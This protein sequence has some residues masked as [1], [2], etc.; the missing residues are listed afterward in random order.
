MAWGKNET[1]TEATT[2]TTT[3]TT[4]DNQT[5]A[6]ASP[7]DAVPVTN[8]TRRPPRKPRAD[9]GKPRL[10]KPAPSDD[11]LAQVL[12]RIRGARAAM[13]EDG[14]EPGDRSDGMNRAHLLLEE[15]LVIGEGRDVTEWL[16]GKVFGGVV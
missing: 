8:H 7:V 5:E 1:T 15:A 9:R 3:E 6:P 11:V 16:R 4:T 2:E 12:E 13:L 10:P 14:H